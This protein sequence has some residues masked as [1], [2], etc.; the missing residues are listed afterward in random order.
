[1]ITSP[2]TP[3]PHPPIVT[4]PAPSP[5]IKV[6]VVGL[7]RAER[8]ERYIAKEGFFR[9]DESALAQLAEDREQLEKL[10]VARLT[11]IERAKRIA[12]GAMTNAIRDGR[13]KTRIPYRPHS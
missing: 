6:A 13:V 9:I 4:K 11:A 1:M 5:T 8:I 12:G 7:A 10:Q 2:T 3:R